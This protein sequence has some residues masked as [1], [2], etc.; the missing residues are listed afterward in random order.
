[1]LWSQATPVA[2]CTLSC[3]YV[4]E[5]TETR[6]V[7]DPFCGLG[8]VL[9]VANQLGLDAVGVEKNRR[10]ARRARSLQLDRD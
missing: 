3:R 1:M 10:R 7:I 9:A 4:L 2:A 8:T 5:R 6:T